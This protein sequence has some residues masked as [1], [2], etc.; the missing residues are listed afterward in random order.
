MYSV[1]KITN[2]IN[3]KCYIGSS[4]RPWRRW[5][6]HINTSKRVNDYK[7]NYPLYQAFRKYG[8][9]NFSFEI[10]NDDF[11]SIEEMQNYERQ[12][13]IAY[14]SYKAGYNQTL[15]TSS[16]NIANENLQKHLNKIK[17]RC[18]LV[19]KDNNILELY[20][21][22]HDAARKNNMDGDYCATKV[23]K[24][25][26]GE[27]SSI[28]NR[29]IF[30][31]VNEYNQII[32][33]PLKP[34]KGRKAL[35]GFKIDSPED[36]IYF[37]SISEAANGLSTDRAS[38]SKCIQGNNRYSHVKGYIFRELDLNGNIIEC[39]KTVED[40]INEYND[41]NPV[42]NGERHSI[43]EWCSIYN[44]S[45]NAYYKRKKMGMTSIEALTIPKRR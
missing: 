33:Q 45:R 14:N 34:Y 28:E 40:R 37:S 19:D 41:C 36:E 24:V 27:C 12:M 43:T 3:G 23:R 1:Y 38:I 21:S 4:V 31:D 5:K 9:D 2:L 18:A 7:Y 22:Y 13:I 32:Y 6:D 44:I 16:N 15:N 42:I 17:K 11:Q 10:L 29:L 35:I 30:R 20:E 26:K 39:E 25:C 8:I